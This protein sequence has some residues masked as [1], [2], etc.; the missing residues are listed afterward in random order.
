M[1][2]IVCEIQKEGFSLTH[3]LLDVLYG[4]A[5]ERLGEENFL[6]MILIQTR[7]RMGRLGCFGPEALGAVVTARLADR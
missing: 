2:G 5:C 6:A 7:D 4:F 3:A 1:D